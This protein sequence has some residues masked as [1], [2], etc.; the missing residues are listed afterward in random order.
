[1]R[2]EPRGAGEGGRQRLVRDQVIGTTCETN[3]TTVSDYRPTSHSQITEKLIC[4][5]QTV[6]MTHRGTRP[7][8][9]H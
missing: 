9:S 1:M 3:L 8:A 4:A 2:Q 5:P 7:L 6:S